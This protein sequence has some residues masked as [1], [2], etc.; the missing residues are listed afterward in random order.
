MVF[1]SKTT[2]LELIPYQE[3][4]LTKK[5]IHS[6]RCIQTSHPLRPEEDKG[7][8]ELYLMEEGHTLLSLWD[9]VQESIVGE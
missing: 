3:K 6:I 1:N 7:E 2:I 4:H 5:S 8:G 9:K